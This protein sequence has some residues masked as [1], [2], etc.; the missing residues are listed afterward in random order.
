MKRPCLAIAAA[1][2]TCVLS[3]PIQAAVLEASSSVTISGLTF[4]LID[5]DPTDG[6][7][8]SVQFADMAWDAPV[9]QD[10]WTARVTTTTS[11]WPD[12]G[13]TI[14]SDVQSQP[15]DHTKLILPTQAGLSNTAGQGSAVIAAS[16]ILVSASSTM[17]AAAAA[18]GRSQSASASA[19]TGSPM[20]DYAIQYD[21]S[22]N[23]AVR[24]QGQYDLSA[25]VQAEDAF[26]YGTAQ[27]SFAM[28][29]TE[30]RTDLEIYEHS[31][32]DL[33][34][35]GLYGSPEDTRS[36]SFDFLLS[37]TSAKVR[38]QHLSVR[39]WAGTSL[40]GATIDV[41]EPTSIALLLAGLSVAS[42]TATGRMRKGI[43]PSAAPMKRLPAMG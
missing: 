13:A 3:T 29:A 24:I 31:A 8:P 17:D 6:I 15:G 38:T 18:T 40:A 37:N 25:R 34:E 41:P 39:T 30:W 27:A 4:N 23:T 1:M 28:F 16:S 21:L 36:G 10:R 9:G 20:F 19:N 22:P 43:Q 42:I 26:G 32:E 14:E 2:S 5:L 7:T 12:S 11:T 35:A 33:A